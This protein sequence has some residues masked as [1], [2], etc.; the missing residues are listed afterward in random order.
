MNAIDL[1]VAIYDNMEITI[2]AL[3]KLVES[4]IDDSSSDMQI[5]KQ[6]LKINCLT[7]ETIKYLE[8]IHGLFKI[9][10]TDFRQKDWMI[11]IK[12]I[13]LNF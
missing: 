7:H 10:F 8:N 5:V 6:L 9:A 11:T 1:A 2:P 4:L 12:K 3:K 13:C